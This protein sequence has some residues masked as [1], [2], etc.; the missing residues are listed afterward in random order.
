VYCI[1]DSFTILPIAHPSAASVYSSLWE[2]ILS[3]TNYVLQPFLHEHKEI[4]ALF[5]SSIDSYDRHFFHLF[6]LLLLKL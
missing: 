4:N 2:L 1:D 6:T 5:I 3:N